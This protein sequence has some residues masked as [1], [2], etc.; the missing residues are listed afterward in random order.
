VQ[1]VVEDRIV[2]GCLAALVLAGCSAPA[3]HNAPA[4]FG[5]PCTT[6]TNLDADHCLLPWPSS[7]FLVADATTRTG[8]R[9]AIPTDAM[10]RNR[11]HVLVDPAP[12]NRA[13]G[14]SPMTTVMVQLASSIDATPLP[15]WHDPSASLAR[16]SPTLI[17]DVDSGERVAH[18]A[19]IE[20]SPE[21][22]RGHTTLYLRPAA[23]LR[24]ARHYAVA[25]RGLRDRGGAAIAASA[26]FAALRD[27]RAVAAEQDTFDR[28]VFAPLAAA[29]VARAELQ[30]AWDFRTASGASAW[31][32]VV[33][34]RDAAF[35]T[36][37]ASGLG[38]S[39]TSVV[40]DPHDELIAR[41]ITGTITVPSFL[42]ASGNAIVRDA[43][44]PAISGTRRADFVAIIPRSATAPAPLWVYGHGL[45]STRDEAT[46]D[47]VR[48]T[49]SRAGAVVVATDFIGLTSDD[50]TSVI[51]SV[52]DMSRFP[53]VLDR[54]RQGMIDTLLLPRTVAGACA[55]FP[56]FR[57]DDQPIASR[58][59]FGYLGNSMGGTLGVA[60]AALS[61]D[62]ARFALGAGGADFAVM[63]PRTT[64]WPQLETFFS[65]GY[66]TRLDRDLL[67]VMAQQLWELAEASALAPHVLADALPGSH[68]ARV[69]FQVGLHDADTSNVASELAARTLDIGELVPTA[70]AV[71]GVRPVAPPQTSAFVYYDLGASPLPDGTLPP[72]AENGVHEGVRR[73]PRAQRQI[74]AFLHDGGTIVDTCGGPC[75]PQR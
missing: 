66:P 40:E 11:D 17:I 45:L 73:D 35:A 64:R 23:R 65:L 2:R 22:A 36:A 8:F 31:G 68:R 50:A 4:R 29:G 70:H 49:A 9:L 24:E 46:R 18:F 41:Q 10:P 56:A 67:I 3:R 30:L 71:W 13:D 48:A 28:D 74:A 63:M 34:M 15:T 7:A 72:P 60:L 16:D 39:V 61:P 62:I 12:W 14:F 54:L 6:S 52:Q 25:I 53:A 33:A 32:D 27:G 26:P 59:D 20:A 57:V 38:C 69:L 42:D 21:V 51:A 37:G 75:A 19:E 1:F 44:R 58:T 55:A 43:G 5:P 47:F